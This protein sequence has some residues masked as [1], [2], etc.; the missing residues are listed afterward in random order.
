MGRKRR[1]PRSRRYLFLFLA[2]LGAILLYLDRLLEEREL[3]DKAIQALSWAAVGQVIVIDP[4]HGGIDAGAVG[5]SGTLEK[6][7]VLAISLQLAKILRLTGA[8]VILTRDKDGESFPELDERVKMAKDRQA[9]MFIS[10]HANA[11]DDREY[12][13]QVFYDPPS[14][15]G[16]RLAENIQAAISER[17]QNTERA[18]AALDAYVLRNQ[19]IPAVI[20]EVGFLSNPREENL[21]RKPAYQKEMALAITH[22]ILKYLSSQPKK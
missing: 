20:V 22:G 8:E 9:T 4:G 2:L 10:V 11:F 21:L 14:Q 13:A 6:D 15:E 17:L 5:P 3:A 7:I 16:R 1:N 18:A 19:Q 12:G